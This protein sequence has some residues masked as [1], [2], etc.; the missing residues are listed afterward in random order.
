MDTNGRTEETLRI[1]GVGLRVSD[2]VQYA[3]WDVTQ[4]PRQRTAARQVRIA[5]KR[6]CLSI[7]EGGA[8]SKKYSG[9]I[10]S[11][12]LR[13]TANRG[14]DPWIG[15]QCDEAQVSSFEG[16]P[17]NKAAH[18]RGQNGGSGL[19]RNSRHRA[20]CPAAAGGTLGRWRTPRNSLWQRRSLRIESSR[21]TR[22]LYLAE[23]ALRL[24]VRPTTRA[25]RLAPILTGSSLQMNAPAPE[26][27]IVIPA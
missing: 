2:H 21:Q 20:R 26:L 16:P 11:S 5:G 1:E 12:R 17:V 3:A 14:D 24:P 4:K 27:S 7:V 9:I 8:V 6:A 19:R 25:L 15:R 13:V 23:V 18:S 10:G 22:R